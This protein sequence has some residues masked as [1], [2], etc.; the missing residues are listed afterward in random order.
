MHPRLQPSN[1]E[2]LELLLSVH[3]YQQFDD[4]T[5]EGKPASTRPQ[6]RLPRMLAWPIGPSQ[7]VPAP[8]GRSA[9]APAW[10]WPSRRQR[11]GD[12]SPCMKRPWLAQTY[13]S[14]TT[15]IRSPSAPFEAH[16][17]LRCRPPLV[18]SHLIGLTPAW[19]GK[20][21]F[22]SPRQTSAASQHLESAS[23]GPPLC[24]PAPSW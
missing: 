12:N 6:S 15:L 19:L 17:D 16:R 14:S 7:V 10:L 13:A 5:S 8:L 1:V 22:S 24:K 20:R 4:Y 18:F 21:A 2:L 3:T 11:L 23:I 9:V